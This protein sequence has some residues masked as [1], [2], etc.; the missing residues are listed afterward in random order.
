[1]RSGAMPAKLC[2]Q[3]YVAFGFSSSSSCPAHLSSAAAS[4]RSILTYIVVKQVCQLCGNDPNVLVIKIDW[5]ENKEICKALDIKASSSLVS[6][7]TAFKEF[8]A[9]YPIS[10]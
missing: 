10:V 5:D 6:H 3:R 1:M 2:F 8:R 7:D 9:S 4:A